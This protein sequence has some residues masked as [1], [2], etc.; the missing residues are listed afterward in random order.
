[1]KLTKLSLVTIVAVSAMTTTAMAE[2]TTVAGKAQVYYYT[3]D[4]T[5]AGDLGSGAT[6]STGTAVTLDVAHKVTDSITANFTALGHTHLGEEMGE[7]AFEG[8]N[9]GGF[10]NVAN[11]TGTFGDTTVVVGR[12]LLA[13][14]MLGGFDWLL[15]PGAFEAGTVVN[16]SL[17]NVTLIA[18]YVNR[19]RS[20][21]GGDN[22]AKLKDDNYAFG[23]GYS[24]G[25]DLN[26]WY[27]N[28][29]AAN[30]TQVYADASKTFDTV[31][32]GLQGVNT[33]NDTAPD[34]TA[35]GA[36][37][38]G[39]FAGIDA[40]VAYNK[41]QDNATNFV[42]ADSLYTSSWNTM[43]STAGS[44]TNDA[45]T[46]KVELSKNFGALSATASYADY[47]NDADETDLILGYAAQKN[48]S[49]DAIYSNTTYPGAT[50]DD[51]AVEL[52]GTYTF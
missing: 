31:T 47:D 13:T 8:S 24:D 36:K 19:H 39:N 48:L 6:S 35:Y 22:F 28:V 12:Q 42:G 37:V 5:G 3:N 15:A 25:I 50:S 4:A 18:S 10:F 7:T 14:P 51:T 46:Y 27:Y 26:L 45:D 20:N 16:K 49:F 34:A 29:D 32:V 21:N 40:S 1:M 52:V 9:A 38:S 17:E 23:A 41:L 11:L 43:A 2:D 44:T 30:Y 33:N